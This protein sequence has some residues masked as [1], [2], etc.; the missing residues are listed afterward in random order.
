ME[1]FKNSKNKLGLNL[2]IK[3]IGQTD[4]VDY[5]DEF[6]SNQEQ[7]SQSWRD[8]IDKNQKIK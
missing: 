4:N 3:Q 8:Q 2:D 7:F 5:Q 6:M 1:G